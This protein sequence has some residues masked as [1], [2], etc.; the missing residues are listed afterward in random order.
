MIDQP[1][2]FNPQTPE[3]IKDLVLELIARIDGQIGKIEAELTARLN[4]LRELYDHDVARLHDECRGE[5]HRLRTERDAIVRALVEH[6]IEREWAALKV[7]AIET[8]AGL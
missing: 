1:A 3:Q 4:R 2:P 7:L 8:A 5:I 6:T